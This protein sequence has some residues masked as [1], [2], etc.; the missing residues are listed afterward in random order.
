MASFD[1]P[2][3]IAAMRAYVDA[4]AALEQAPDDAQVLSRSDAKSLAG[5][6]LRKKL[7]DLG[8]TA[9][10]SQRANGAAGSR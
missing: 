2:D 7:V 9:P 3:L 8:W 4:S 5:M 10:A 1:D 6:Q